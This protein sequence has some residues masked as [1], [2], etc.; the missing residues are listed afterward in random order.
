MDDMLT[1][2]LAGFDAVWQRVTG[3]EGPA[4]APAAP[5]PRPDTLLD[6]MRAEVCAAACASALARSFPA[7]GRAVL[8]RHAAD[9]RRHLRRLQA[10]YFIAAGVQGVPGGDCPAPAGKLAALRALFLQAED[11]AGRYGQAAAQTDCDAL[12]QALSAFAADERC[13]AQELRAL[14]VES[15]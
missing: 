15:F 5:V 6:L 8:L 13:R 3:R 4:A 2:S 14:L 12:Q 7:G 1:E 11:M 10:E 9:A